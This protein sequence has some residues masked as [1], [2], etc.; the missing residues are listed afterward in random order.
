M[1]NEL[2]LSLR[3]RPELNCEVVVYLPCCSGAAGE[4]QTV[5]RID[6]FRIYQMGVDIHRLADFQERETQASSLFV[7]IMNAI[8][9]IASLLSDS[10]PT[11]IEI[12]R[13]AAFD[14]QKSLTDLQGKHFSD[15]SGNFAFPEQSDMVQ[16]WEIYT[17]RDKLRVFEA[18]FK[19]E[20]ESAATYKVAKKGIYNTGDLVDRADEAFKQSLIPYIGKT[21]LDEYQAAGRCYAFGLFTASGYHSCRAA[22]AVLR[23]YYRLFTGKTCAGDENW[24]SLLNDLCGG[25]KGQKP[26]KDAAALAPL[27]TLEQIKHLKDFDRNPLSH[28]RSVLDESSADELL[29]RSKVVIMAMAGDIMAKKESIEP[30]LALVPPDGEEAA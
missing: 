10:A 28:L 18:A 5:E 20:M 30:T 17:V 6:L 1:K 8:A 23:E 4:K 7:P 16:P 26:A 22:D 12:S 14:L 29:S 9:A 13:Q 2:E 11:K 15:Q 21:A 3:D 27:G 19:A 24:G 25:Q